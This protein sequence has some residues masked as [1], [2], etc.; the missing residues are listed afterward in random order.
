MSEPDVSV[1][2]GRSSIDVS[3]L[4][5]GSAPLG[6]LLR[7]TSESDALDAVRTALAQGIRYFD[8]A[9][10]YGGGMAEQ[11]LG[12]VL[13]GVPRDD[14]VL[15]TKVG[16]IVSQATG[17]AT[18]AGGF[19]GAPPYVITY[20]YSYDGVLRSFEASLTRLQLDRIDIL[21]IHDVNRKYHGQNVMARFEE[22]K[23][24]ACRALV[25]LR[26]EGVISA[27][28][29]AL[30]EVDVA[31]RFV[32]ETDVDCIMLPQRYTPL[33][34][35]AG[36]ELLP[37][38]KSRKI[39]VLVA[40]PFDSGILATGAIAQATYNY[41]QAT[42]EILARVKSIE[43]LCAEF[44]V[45]LQAVALQFALQNDAVTSVVTGMRSQQEVT[46]NLAFMRKPIPADFWT[47]LNERVLLKA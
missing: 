18:A 16:K 10:Q 2:L 21:L 24:G 20:D 11:R 7:E 17:T 6:G 31:L 40:A 5:F 22:A 3:R 8:V 26:D 34:S 4:G 27:F 45:Q 35:S 41:Q 36:A 12:Q 29:P 42:P 14:F 47:R 28:G 1:R 23:A 43:M 25:K 32:R 15:S 46:Q 9:P 39:G 13:S 19:V 37:L 30:N 38:C 33:D 44:E